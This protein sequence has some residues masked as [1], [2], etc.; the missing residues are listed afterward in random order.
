MSEWW[1]YRFSDFLMFSP[2]VYWRL[3]ERYNREAWPLHLLML[4][5]GLWLLWL[6][7]RRR[8]I[9]GRFVGCVLALVWLWV[10][11]GFH[12]RTYAQINWAAEAMAA[13][14]L[15]EAALL[16][17]LP[18]PWAGRNMGIAGPRSRRIGL[19]LTGI[20]VVAYPLAGVLAGRPWAQ[21][22]VFGLMPE[23]TALATLGLLLATDQPHRAWL[24]L[25]P[26]LSLVVGWATLWQLAN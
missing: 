4:G 25:I 12:H 14:F 17:C 21:V 19:W 24:A 16:P 20:A 1:T 18:V 11:W 7:A 23:P 2:S 9:A 13:T 3:V 8:L 15:L 22:E 6:A 26:L 5:V 10:S